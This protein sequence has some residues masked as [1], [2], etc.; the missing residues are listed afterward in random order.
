[1]F[2]KEEKKKKRPPQWKRESKSSTSNIEQLPLLQADTAPKV[3][4]WIHSWVFTLPTKTCQGMNFNFPKRGKHRS[5]RWKGAQRIQKKKLL[6]KP[7]EGLEP[8]I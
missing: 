2:K 5:F 1:M 7:L 8:K 6:E 4:L 3:C